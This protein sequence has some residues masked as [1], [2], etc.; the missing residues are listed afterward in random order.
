MTKHIGE[1]P[2]L[3]HSELVK[4]QAPQGLPFR[5]VRYASPDARARLL[6]L[7]GRWRS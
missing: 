2:Q 7:L 1:W 6:R 3:R 5:V 4:R